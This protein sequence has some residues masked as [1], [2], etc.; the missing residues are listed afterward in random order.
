[1]YPCLQRS[2]HT[3]DTWA[4]ECWKGNFTTH[5]SSLQD[6][7]ISCPVAL[8]LILR[9]GSCAQNPLLWILI[10]SLCSR[11]SR[12]FYACDL[13]LAILCSGPYAH[14]LI[15]NILCSGSYAQRIMYNSL[16]RLSYAKHLI[17]IAKP[18]KPTNLVWRKALAK[19]WGRSCV[20]VLRYP[21]AGKVE[22]NLWMASLRQ[23]PPWY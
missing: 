13:M 5:K 8:L 15:P 6:L 17:R 10:D 21:S 4:R 12:T 20:S 9:L 22:I 3:K 2:V 23:W 19:Q 7:R 16:C 18:H 11:F 1:M 14:Y